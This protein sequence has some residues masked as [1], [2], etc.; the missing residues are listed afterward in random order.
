MKKIIALA[1]LCAAAL[2]TGCVGK[3][4][5]HYSEIKKAKELYEKL[6]SAHMTMTDLS[7]GGEI[8]EF[9]FYLNEKDEM[10]FSYRGTE[11]G[12]ESQAYSDGAQFFY[13]S[14]DEDGWR[15][16]DSSDES[17]LYN[18]YTRKYRYP[19]AR[20]SIFFLDGTSVASASSADGANGTKIVT[21]VYDPQKLNSYAASRLDNVSEFTELT[22]VYEIDGEGRMVSFTETGTVI[23]EQGE[24]SAVNM[25]ITVDSMNEVWE[26]ANPVGELITE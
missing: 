24:S 23:D 16:I 6:D 12:G 19:Y 10:I 13:K 20:G 2:M 1:V 15:V 14:A 21:Y 7:T 3:T 9:S 18:L 22:A 8:L 4:P 17:Y 26:I 25:K 11:D 5:E